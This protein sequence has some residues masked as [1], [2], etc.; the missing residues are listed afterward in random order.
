[1]TFQNRLVRAGYRV[2]RINAQEIH[3][4]EPKSLREIFLKHYYYGQNIGSFIQKDKR[5]AFTT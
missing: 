5:R 1:M 3:V 4:G 2:G